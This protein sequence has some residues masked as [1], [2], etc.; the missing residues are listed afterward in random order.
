MSW[1]QLEKL[2]NLELKQDFLEAENSQMIKCIDDVEMK[3]S[4]SQ[5]ETAIESVCAC[6]FQQISFNVLN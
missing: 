6:T 2:Q 1:E 4:I 3:K 5:R